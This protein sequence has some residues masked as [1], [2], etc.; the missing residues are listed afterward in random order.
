M[1]PR[2]LEAKH[3]HH[4]RGTERHVITAPVSLLVGHAPG[5]LPGGD[6]RVPPPADRH[7]ARTPG[8]CYYADALLPHYVAG[9]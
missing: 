5:R 6:R 7:P 1:P 4:D 8:C 9:P 2:S 3:T